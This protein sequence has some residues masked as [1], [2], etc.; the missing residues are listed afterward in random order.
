M[1]ERQSPAQPSPR[2]RGDRKL[3]W[4]VLVGVMGVP[5]LAV[6]LSMS[7]SV[8]PTQAQNR[9]PSTTPASDDL[10]DAGVHENLFAPGGLSI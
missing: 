9:R 8:S 1:H 6:V 2:R 4:L 10:R 7:A 5:V 3:A